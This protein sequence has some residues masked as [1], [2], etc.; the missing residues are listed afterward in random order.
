MGSVTNIRY[1]YHKTAIET[2]DQDKHKDRDKNKNLE[3]GHIIF[4]K[5]AGV[6]MRQVINTKKRQKEHFWDEVQ[7]ANLFLE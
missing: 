2:N 7:R 6:T 5:C 1:A 3:E 4:V